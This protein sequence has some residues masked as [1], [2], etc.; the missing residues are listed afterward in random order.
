MIEK[1]KGSALTNIGEQAFEK[2]SK[3][4]P[5]KVQV[6]ELSERMNKNYMDTLKDTAIKG[7]DKYSGTFFVVV[8]TKKEKLIQKTI[9]NYF[10]ARQSCPAPSYDQAVYSFDSAS[11]DLRFLWMIPSKDLC[12][13]MYAQ[14]YNLELINDP[15]LPFV[16]GFV[17]GRLLDKAI[18]LNLKNDI[19]G[20]DIYNN[21]DGE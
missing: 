1:E 9:R 3:Y 18:G 11:E 12:N 15:L 20:S 19:Y 5:E 4:M 17:E 14:R 6:R 21:L 2:Q 7:K 16:V 8:L 13:G 10:Y